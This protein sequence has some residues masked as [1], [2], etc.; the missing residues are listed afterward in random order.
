MP[1]VA[2]P[3]ALPHALSRPRSLRS[4]ERSG[5]ALTEPAAGKRT[6]VTDQRVNDARHAQRGCKQDRGLD[7]AKFFHLGRTSK[8]AEGVAHENSTRN[9]LAKKIAGMRQ[10]GGHLGADVV[11]PDDGGVP[12]LQ[13]SN[14]GD[15]IER[16]GR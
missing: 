5:R 6:H 3:G 10:G 1:F 15:R 12:N 7:L 8:L 4:R 13:A 16:P 14:I 11:A 9:F 2:V